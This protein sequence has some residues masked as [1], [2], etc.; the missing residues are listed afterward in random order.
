[1]RG[2]P[3]TVMVHVR[4]F[5]I[6]GALAL[7]VIVLMLAGIN[8]ISVLTGQFAGPPPLMARTGIA[9]IEAGE[10]T[11][12]EFMTAL[13]RD[14]DAYWTQAFWVSKLPYASPKFVAVADSGE[15]GC[16]MAGAAI[17]TFYCPLEATVYVDLSSYE[18]LR[19]AF[20]EVA[21]EAQAYRMGKAYGHH[22]QNELD[23]LAPFE[24]TRAGMSAEA[25]LVLEQQFSAQAACYVA[26]WAGYA[27][28]GRLLD[29]PALVEAIDTVAELMPSQQA[30]HIPETFAPAGAAFRKE[31]FDNGW[32]LPVGGTCKI[33]LIGPPY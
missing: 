29:D 13:N 15:L 7:G 17:G 28:I 25:V 32:A 16:G 3:D 26:V 10:A 14:A 31:W 24:A 18:Q 5:G 4:R 33:G 6:S 22:T 27:R 1:M 9:A 11:L 21:A 8:P 30:R 12:E 19:V 20:P 23:L 2:I